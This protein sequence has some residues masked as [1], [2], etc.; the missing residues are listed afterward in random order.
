M[1]LRSGMKLADARKKFY[2]AY[3]CATIAMIVIFAPLCVAVLKIF[4]R[5][6]DRDAFKENA[7]RMS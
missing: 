6:R 1:I 5:N 3:G 4:R 7:I 2:V